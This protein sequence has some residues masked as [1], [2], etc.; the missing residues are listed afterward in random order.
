MTCQYYVYLSGFEKYLV[1]LNLLKGMF[2]SR[3]P[4]YT[5]TRAASERHFWCVFAAW[6]LKGV[7]R[8]LSRVIPNNS[9][10]S[11]ANCVVYN[12]NSTLVNVVKH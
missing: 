5:L 2:T 8:G 10:L 11:G 6:N 1:R 3:Y 12:H 9:L 7:C 4:L